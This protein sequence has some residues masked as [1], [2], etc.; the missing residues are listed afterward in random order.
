MCATLVCTGNFRN[1]AHPPSEHPMG[2]YLENKFAFKRPWALP[3]NKMYALLPRYDF[4][5]YIGLHW[6]AFQTHF[7]DLLCQ[8]FFI[9]TPRVLSRRLLCIDGHV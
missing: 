8:T 6:H 9:L 3:M 2:V 5:Y 1:S 7:H 4:V